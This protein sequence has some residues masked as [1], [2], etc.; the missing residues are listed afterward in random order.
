MAGRSPGSNSR[1][2]S[3]QGA[4]H[5]RLLL[6]QF[7]QDRLEQILAEVESL[8]RSSLVIETVL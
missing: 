5:A 3:R 7:G 1:R 6:A 8:F 4:D 2:N